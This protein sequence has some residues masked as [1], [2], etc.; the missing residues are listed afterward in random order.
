MSNDDHPHDQSEQANTQQTSAPDFSLPAFTID[1]RTKK[2]LILALAV[3]SGMFFSTFS[4][5]LLV[6][7]GILVASGQAPKQVD[8]FLQGLPF[9]NHIAK[10]INQ[11]ERYLS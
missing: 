2:G 7:A 11:I 9:G 8:D 4:L 5:L 1:S 10:A 3:I 6:I